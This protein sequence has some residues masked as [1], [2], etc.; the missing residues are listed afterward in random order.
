MAVFSETDDAYHA[1]GFRV[2]HK[3]YSKAPTSEELKASALGIGKLGEKAGI[4]FSCDLP[5][6]LENT[7]ESSMSL[8]DWV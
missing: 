2:E 8:D 6:D 5:D 3:E 4:D 7:A 1:I